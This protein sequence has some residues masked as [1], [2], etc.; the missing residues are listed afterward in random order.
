MGRDER[1]LW[2]IATLF[3]FLERNLNSIL[4][5]LLI[6]AP[7]KAPH[8]VDSSCIYTTCHEVT[9][10]Q[11]PTPQQVTAPILADKCFPGT[12]TQLINPQPAS[13]RLKSIRRIDLA[14][15]SSLRS[16]D[17]IQN[18]YTLHIFNWRRLMNCGGNNTRWF[19]FTGRGMRAWNWWNFLATV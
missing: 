2:T 11:A 1:A 19:L 3:R 18:T 10:L 4:C 13:C 14:S 9:P 12:K 6:L 16:A 8:Q 17:V 5:V 15:L 7:W